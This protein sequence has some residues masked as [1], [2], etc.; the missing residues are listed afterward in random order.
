MQPR[1]LVPAQ[2]VLCM[3]ALSAQQSSRPGEAPARDTPAQQQQT[4][5]PT[6]KIAG[7]VLSAADGRPVKRARA[8]V[9]APQLAEG[10]GTLTDDNGVFELTDLPGGRYTLSVSKTG[11][12]SLSYGQR[13]PLQAGTPLQL[14]D[15]QQLEGIEFRLPR[16]SVIA[17]HLYDE[18]GE[19]MPGASVR[20]LRYQ[21]AQ[22][23]RQ[24]VPAGGAQTDDQGAFRVWG[25][26]PG[27]YYLNATAQN[28]NLGRGARGSPP[29][30]G[31]GPAAFA[32]RGSAAPGLPATR[33]G[34]SGP[35]PG[36]IDFG[37]NEE[38]LRA[39]APTYYPG[40]GSV[41]ESRP[42]NVAVGQELLDVN[43][44]I[45]LVRT[46]QVAGTVT[47]PDGSI[48][49]SG[50]VN[51]APETG[52]G[53]DGRSQLGINFGS[54]IDWEGR[55]SIGNVPPGRYVLRA[56]GTDSDP[57]LFAAQPITVA[58]GDE[59][60]VPII[61]FPGASIS[62]TVA[63][64]GADPPDMSRI[65]V[66]APS[67]ESGGTLGPNPNAKVDKDGS[68][69]L[70]GVSVGSHWIRSAGQTNGW[71]LK[72]VL[73]S[74]RDLIDTPIELR[75]GQALG[76]VS[77]VFTNKRQEING[78][79][80]NEQGQPVTDY[81]VLAFAVDP[82]H[83]RPLTRHIGTARPD[84]NGRFQIRNLPA[85]EY[86]VVTVDPA[87][88]GEWFEPAFLDQHRVSAMRVTLGDGDI[89]TQDF[90]VSTR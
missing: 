53:P 21:Y 37:G 87:E 71:A 78:T 40:V 63:F 44:S 81:T 66:T 79:V 61:L 23:E 29:G 60:E 16:G 41:N 69:T 17:G 74:G 6:G 7:R 30:G 22:G 67:A 10:R 38:L 36:F 50:Q 19:P 89:K 51:L 62:G 59:L 35:P 47:S 57:P 48:T 27:E 12:V 32:G 4:P 20:V 90:R 2:V 76:S 82:D 85:G 14:G 54:R 58:S 49:Y 24:L 28:F 52:A 25:L 65:R 5:A 70:E 1:L 84:Q 88:Q 43:F 46:A 3:C 39:Y 33:A 72:S 31:R 8:Y 13:R 45:L 83:W 68:F 55:F 9:S 56:R 75:S 11:F 64:E 73:V 77:L 80:T 42:L 18:L 86:Y 34:F 15:G 26:N